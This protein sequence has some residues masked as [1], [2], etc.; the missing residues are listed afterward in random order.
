MRLPNTSVTS[1]ALELDGSNDYI[2]LPPE[3]IPSGKEITFS[4]W[5]YGDSTLPNKSC[6]IKV[7]NEQNQVIFNVHLPWINRRIYLIVEETE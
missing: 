4:L 5:A 3:S 7:Y 1:S 2:E 6:L